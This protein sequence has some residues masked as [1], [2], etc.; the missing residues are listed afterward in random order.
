MASPHP[1]RPGL[2]PPHPSLHPWQEAEALAGDAGE[3][4]AVQGEQ[5]LG[6]TLGPVLLQLLPAR[7]LQ[8]DLG[9]EAGQVWV[10]GGQS[11][12]CFSPKASAPSLP[13]KQSILLGCLG[14]LPHSIAPP[15]GMTTKS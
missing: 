13:A 5:R 12:P 11:A 14:H 7:L 2:E 10:P 3:E 6:T 8:Q 9:A 15:P 4:A 1:C